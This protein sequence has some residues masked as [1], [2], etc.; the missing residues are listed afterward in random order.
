MQKLNKMDTLYRLITSLSLLS[1]IAS[2]AQAEQ[3]GLFT[4]HV[5]DGEVT[6]HSYPRDASGP[7]DIPAEIDGHPVTRI[8]AWAFS[9]CSELTSVTIPEGVTSIGECAFCGCTGLHSV[10]LAESVTSIGR[11][12]FSQCSGLP[13]ISIPSGVTHI[14]WKAFEGCSGATSLMI[15]EGVTGIRI[16]SLC[17]L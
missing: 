4:Y 8:R 17:W 10:S 14:G 6:I 5:N 11:H 7:V 12:A 1:I 9:G 13:S 3:F 16:C 2:P 15:A